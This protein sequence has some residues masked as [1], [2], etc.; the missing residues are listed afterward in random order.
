MIDQ[1]PTQIPTADEFSLDEITSQEE[2]DTKLT[3]WLENPGNIP[4]V[5]KGTCHF[6]LRIQNMR[7]LNFTIE[8]QNCVF[9]K[10]VKIKSVI[11]Q[12]GFTFSNCT[13]E[14]TLN[15]ENCEFHKRFAIFS[16]RCLKSAKVEKTKVF[17]NF[18]IDN[19]HF[20]SGGVFEVSYHDGGK[21]EIQNIN[22]A[23]SGTLFFKQYDQEGDTI[24]SQKNTSSNTDCVP[25][26]FRKCYLPPSTIYLI[27]WDLGHVSIE[28]GNGLTG[29][30]FDQ[31]IFPDSTTRQFP[32]ENIKTYLTELINLY[33]K[34]AQFLNKI[35][36]LYNKI[37]HF[38][39]KT[40]I[41]CNKTTQFLNKIIINLFFFFDHFFTWWVHHGSLPPSLHEKYT[42]PTEAMQGRITYSQLKAKAQERGEV[43][44]AHSFYFW[45]SWFRLRGVTNC[46]SPE[47][48]L[49][50]LYLYSSHF[51]LSIG[52]PIVWLFINSRVFAWIYHSLNAP[53][54]VNNT[55]QSIWLK[56][57]WTSLN[58]SLPTDYFI[59][60]TLETTWKKAMSCHPTLM[61]VSVTCQL[62]IQGFLVFQL[63]AAIRN[64]VKR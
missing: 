5:F 10:P 32:I 49:L 43:Q 36:D 15:I 47:G 17:G 11:F 40:I 54:L 16:S 14:N 4:L 35:I 58:L 29:F 46:I 41:Y 56:H 28:G 24:E 22:Y 26:T 37:T 52:L 48:V 2:L 30:I 57:W 51:G 6:E 8:F 18:I 63:I 62:I 64:K 25:L 23:S 59:K 27:Q 31:C 20:E 50:R 1:I 7:D 53:C 33:N 9:E 44:L 42:S 12:E 3:E 13:F 38:T 19:T 21:A 60:K 55:N 39:N 34:P 61:S 45:E